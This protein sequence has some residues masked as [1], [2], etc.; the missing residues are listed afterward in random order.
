MSSK[1]AYWQ[2]ASKEIVLGKKDIHVWRIDLEAFQERSDD[3]FSFLSSEEKKRSKRFY[4]EQDKKNYII[5]RGVL[6]ILLGK[7]LQRYPAT[8]QFIYG[9]HGKPFLNKENHKPD[10]RFNISHSKNISL[11]VFNLGRDIGVDV[12]YIRKIHHLSMAKR[13]FSPDEEKEILSL[14]GPEQLEA[15]FSFWTKKE[16]FI[17]A[18]GGGLSVPLRSFSVSST[19]KTKAR[20]TYIANAHEEEKVWSLFDI[21]VGKEYTA[22]CAVKGKNLFLKCCVFFEN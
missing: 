5:T 19:K 18:Q 10:I 16:A 13:F 11:I 3:L 7:Y 9:E 21:E 20:I 22:A 2:K 12:E 15:F 8:I 17:K 14:P 4:F 6:R 1:S